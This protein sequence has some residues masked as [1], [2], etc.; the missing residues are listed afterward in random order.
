MSGVVHAKH[1][2][3][4]SLAAMEV[5]NVEVFGAHQYF[6]GAHQVRVHNVYFANQKA[7]ELAGEIA[8]AES[9]GAKIVEAGSKGFDAAINQG[10]VKFVVTQ[11]GK[12]LISPHTVNGVEISHAVLS[13][14]Q[15]VLAAGQANIAGA[16]GVYYG[17]DISNY[18]GHFMPDAASLDIAK[19]AFA[20]VG[21]TF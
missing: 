9:V 2:R 11:D 15:D 16:N 5:F 13:G 18:S 1:V 19:N 4:A 7:S 3:T 21:V 20:A 10:T 8:R 6:V 12:L 14:G 17:L